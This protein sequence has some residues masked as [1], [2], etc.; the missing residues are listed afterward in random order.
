M[1][2]AVCHIAFNHHAF[3]RT[4]ILLSTC[5]KY[6]LY[7]V[8]HYASHET[9]LSNIPVNRRN[10]LTAAL[11]STVS[12]INIFIRSPFSNSEAY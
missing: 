1:R 5:P 2:R 12:R 6:K 9:C 11:S 8:A 10:A 3:S 4:I 7:T